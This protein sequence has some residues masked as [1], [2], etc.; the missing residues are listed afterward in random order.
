MGKLADAARRT[1]EE[2]LTLPDVPV[3]EQQTSS[4]R[5]SARIDY[6]SSEWRCCL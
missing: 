5:Q 6:R 2:R 1:E 4:L 3:V